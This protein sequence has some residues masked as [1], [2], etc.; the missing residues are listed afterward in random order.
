M[1]RVF[2][3]LFLIASCST[4]QT[5]DDLITK[6]RL[7]KSEVHLIRNNVDRLIKIYDRNGEPWLVMYSS[8]IISTREGKFIFDDAAGDFV[9]DIFLIKERDCAAAE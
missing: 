8:G 6:V 2:C 9:D 7:F 4:A 3:A 5:D 1:R